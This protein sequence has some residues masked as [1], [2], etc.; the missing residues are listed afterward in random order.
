M[1]MEFV[2]WEIKKSNT[3]RLEAFR[4]S[5]RSTHVVHLVARASPDNSRHTFGLGKLTDLLESESGKNF[6]HEVARVGLVLVDERHLLTA[7]K[8]MVRDVVID[9]DVERL[10]RSSDD[11]SGDDA[12]R[13]VDVV[14]MKSAR[15]HFQP[16]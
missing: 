9:Q 4:N 8:A 14:A 2:C 3:K 7:S 12:V 6:E 16:W 13:H 15:F 10:L 1:P 11:R 5:K